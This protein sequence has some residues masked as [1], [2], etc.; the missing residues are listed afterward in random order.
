[1]IQRR[2]YS[3]KRDKNDTKKKIFKKRGQKRYKEEYIPKRGTEI[4]QGRRYSKKGVG[5]AKRKKKF[6]KGGQNCYE[7][8]DIIKRGMELL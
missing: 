8:E 7:E 2:R 6:Q 3:E 1:M 5:N 4:L